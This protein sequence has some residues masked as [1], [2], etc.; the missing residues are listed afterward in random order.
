VRLKKKIYTTIQ[1]A[2]ER[3]GRTIN[4]LFKKIDF[5]KSNSIQSAELHQMF[6]DMQ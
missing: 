2:L 6:K 3:T 1:Q 4:E 5:D